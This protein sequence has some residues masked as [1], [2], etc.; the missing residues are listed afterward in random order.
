MSREIV[1][2]TRTKYVA[3][4]DDL[5]NLGSTEVI[6]E[7]FEASLELVTRILRVYNAPRA[8]VAAQVK[9]IREQRF[10]IFRERRATVPRIRLSSDL[11]VYAETWEM[12]QGCAWDGATVA[13]TRLRSE[14]GALILGVIRGERTVNNP[15]PDERLYAGD[16]LVMSGTKEQ[17]K[18]A[19]ELLERCPPR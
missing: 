19:F 10:G 16:R 11:D 3:D 7:E 17:L 13:Q 5:W 15:G 8:M 18:K 1:I 6:A 4:I 12:P 9:S 14:S 2:L